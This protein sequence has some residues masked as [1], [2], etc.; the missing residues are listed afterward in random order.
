[1]PAWRRGPLGAKCRAQ[2]AYLACRAQGAERRAQGA[3]R[4][5]AGRRG[6]G[7]TV[8]TLPALPGRRGLGAAGRRAPRAGRR[9][10]GAGR[11]QAGLPCQGA[12]R[13]A[14]PSG[15]SWGVDFGHSWAPLSIK[16]GLQM[17]FWSLRRRRAILG[18]F[19]WSF[20]GPPGPSESPSGRHYRTQ[21]ASACDVARGCDFECEVCPVWGSMWIPFCFNF[22][23]FVV[24]VCVRR[25]CS[26]ENGRYAKTTVKHMVLALITLLGRLRSYMKSLFCSASGTQKSQLRFEGRC[27]HDFE[28]H[29]HPFGGSW[30]QGAGPQGA[31]RQGAGRR[32]QGAGRQGAGAQGG[33]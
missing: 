12:G 15:G 28:P 1:M 26:E 9:A 14:G 31:G 5:G 20:W 4:R 33:R 11:R 19:S 32:S 2:G 17:F 24:C 6:A 13:R 30:A 8:L 10:H 3:G 18:G 23:S 25:A 27:G 21:S 29:L 7:R 22:W 16:C